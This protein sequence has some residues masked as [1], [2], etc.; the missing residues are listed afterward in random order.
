MTIPT[1]ISLLTLTVTADATTPPEAHRFTTGA[2]AYPAAKAKA[3][4][5]TEF[6]GEASK[7]LPVTAIGTAV[8]TAG[9][10]IA[11]DTEVEVFGTE[12]KAGPFTDGV[13]VG[14]ALTAASADGDKIEVLLIAGNS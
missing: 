5:V 10:A 8:V 7:A 9:A 2:G 14:R 6:D 11:V 1:S 3:L 12:G 4:G 13:K